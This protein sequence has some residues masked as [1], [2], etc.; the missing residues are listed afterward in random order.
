MREERMQYRAE[1]EVPTV[2]FTTHEY[3]TADEAEQVSVA[4]AGLS[5]AY[6]IAG[7]LAEARAVE[8]TRLGYSDGIATSIQRDRIDISRPLKVLV[9]AWKDDE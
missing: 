1:V 5:R 2:P 3:L 4:L 8:L 7:R 6:K 9:T